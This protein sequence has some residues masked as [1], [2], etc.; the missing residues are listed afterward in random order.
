MIKDD[1]HS[2]GLFIQQAGPQSGWLS[3]N[4]I[5]P[6]K[7][8]APSEVEVHLG[9]LRLL[10]DGMFGRVGG[11]SDQCSSVLSFLYIFFFLENK[12]K[13]LLTLG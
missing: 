4:E 9:L 11:S 6:G 7:T 10:D 2:T 12:R 8:I 3:K 5:W 1:H 13:T